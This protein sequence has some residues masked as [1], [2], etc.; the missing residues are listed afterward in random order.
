M[1]DVVLEKVDSMYPFRLVF[2]TPDRSCVA[3]SEIHALAAMFDYGEIT[4]ERVSH[5]FI[6][7]IGDNP[8]YYMGYVVDFGVKRDAFLRFVKAD[9]ARHRGAHIW[10]LGQQ[11]AGYL[12]LWSFLEHGCPGNAYEYHAAYLGDRDINSDDES[13]YGLSFIFK[14]VLWYK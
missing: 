12:F 9:P 11:E 3:K 2:D 10:V 1:S 13:S 4:L 8:F 7:F 6:S 14:E 5:C